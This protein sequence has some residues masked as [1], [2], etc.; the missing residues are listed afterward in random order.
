MS[1]TAGV[2]ALRGSCPSP[3]GE[4]LAAKS[5]TTSADRPR[6]SDEVGG[7]IPQGFA[8]ILWC[9][10][11]V[12]RVNRAYVAE[13][14]PRPSLL[15]VGGDVTRERDHYREG[16]V[17]FHGNPANRDSAAKPIERRSILP[18]SSEPLN[19]QRFR[20]EPRGLRLLQA[21]VGQPLLSG[22]HRGSTSIPDA[23]RPSSATGA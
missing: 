20:V 6:G 1:S 18:G 21:L 3:W 13:R 19:L 15:F 10:E 11:E 12:F 14:L 8:R 23:T 16:G 7:A 2:T 17:Q 9:L 5:K 4:A 22:P